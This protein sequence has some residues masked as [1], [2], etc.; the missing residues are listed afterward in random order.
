MILSLSLLVT[1]S[2]SR[3]NDDVILKKNQR[4]PFYGVLVG[5]QRYKFYTEQAKLAE[6]HLNNPC[7]DVEEVSSDNEV[8]YFTLGGIALG[9]LL[10]LSVG[11]K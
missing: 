3:A 11:G 7:Q 8:V 4:A 5:E 6:Y 10:G 2:I 9:L 1:T